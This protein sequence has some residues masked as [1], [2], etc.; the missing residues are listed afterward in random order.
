VMASLSSSPA[1][2]MRALRR[3]GSVRNGHTECR[4]SGRSTY[5]IPYRDQSRRH[6]LR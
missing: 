6:H 3:R 1:L 4:G 5:P 2:S